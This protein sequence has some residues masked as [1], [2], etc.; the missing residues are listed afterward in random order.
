MTQ[1]ALSRTIKSLED[2]LGAPLFIRSRKNLTLTEAG[3]VLHKHGQII[4]QQLQR[5][6]DELSRTLLTKKGH[7]RIGLPTITNSFFFSELIA[8]FHKE[9]PEV[10]FQ[11]EEDGSKRIEEKV[12]NNEL[13]F[14]VAVLSDDNQE[15]DF[16]LFIDETLCLVVPTAH[17]LADKESVL[18]EELKDEG[19][20]L[21]NREFELRN[22]IVSAC[23]RVG[24]EPAV[25][26]ETSQL[27]FIEEMVSHS[28]GITLLPESTCAEL[29]RDIVT[30]PVILPAIKWNL[31]IVWKKDAYLSEVAKEFIRF[32][33][34]KLMKS[35]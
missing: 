35:S 18:L 20:I 24:F 1:P 19:F 15:L 32:A 10:T 9:Y 22:S 34:M 8:S 28:L 11:L 33:K 12:L 29:T 5:L 30:I 6:D 4:E 27:D 26:S 14:G 3:Q 23:K 2:E 31:A 16:Y 7:I 17:P 13:D 25:I 21:F